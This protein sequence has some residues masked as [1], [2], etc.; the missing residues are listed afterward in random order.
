MRPV[1]CGACGKPI[2]R[3]SRRGLNDWTYYCEECGTLVRIWLWDNAISNR[4]ENERMVALRRRDM[5]L[6]E[7]YE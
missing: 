1:Y 7:Y 2:C 6:I 3:A 5:W 4:Y